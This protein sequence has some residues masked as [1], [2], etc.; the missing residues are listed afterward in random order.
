MMPAHLL[1]HRNGEVRKRPIVDA[2]SVIAARNP[3]L[4]QIFR[5]L[6]RQTPQPH[7]IQQLKN[8][9]VCANAKRQ[10]KHRHHCEARTLHKSA[11]C[12]ARIAEKAIK[13]QRRIFRI[14]ALFHHRRISK[15][16]PRLA[17]RLV[18]AHALRDIAIDAHPHVLAQ[19]IFNLAVQLGTSAQGPNTTKAATEDTHT[20]PH[21]KRRIACT[22][23]TTCSQFFSRAAS[24]FLPAAVSE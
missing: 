19:F 8:G 12:I 5:T 22:P 3:Q 16:Q 23:F 21:A 9:G 24:C 20:S 7:R 2:E 14:D 6:N 17:Y 10:R 13:A 1:P 15:T 11:H 18:Q 4:R